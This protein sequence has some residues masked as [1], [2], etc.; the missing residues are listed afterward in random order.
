MH[1]LDS[2]NM[3]KLIFTFSL[4]LF[5]FSSCYKDVSYKNNGIIT[6]QDD[7]MCMCCGGW[8]IDIDNTTYR[9]YELPP[10][11]E[12]NLENKTY[13]ILV[14]LNWIIKDE[15]CLGDEIIVE[16]ITLADN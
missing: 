14:K 16:D 3:K 9:F 13:P 1:I 6:G 12:L 11:S 7:R 10:S 4:A 8:F 2:Y 5:T 15:T